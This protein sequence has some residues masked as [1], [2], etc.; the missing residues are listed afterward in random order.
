M[1]LRESNCFR[2]VGRNL[3]GRY[4]YTPDAFDEYVT[5]FDREEEEG[6][7]NS[8]STRRDTLWRN[9]LDLQHGVNRYVA[10]ADARETRELIR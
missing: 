3:T 6:Q 4:K 7:K 8:P 10:T 2:T 9:C 5:R 1:D